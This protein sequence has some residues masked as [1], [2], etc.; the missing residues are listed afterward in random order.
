MHVHLGGVVSFMCYS[1]LY[2]SVS[3]AQH[4]NIRAD[5][6]PWVHRRKIAYEFYPA[7]REKDEAGRAGKEGKEEGGTQEGKPGRK[8][9][10]K[11]G[12]KKERRKED[13]NDTTRY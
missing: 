8:Q 11:V 9:R 10:R 4:R 2:M 5:L 6:G 1:T 12:E 13:R 3:V 7:R